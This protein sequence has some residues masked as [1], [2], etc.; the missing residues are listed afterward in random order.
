MPTYRGRTRADPLCEPPQ[1]ILTSLIIDAKQSEYYSDYA[2]WGVERATK[3]DA[4]I[5][6]QPGAQDPTAQGERWNYKPDHAGG[7][8]RVRLRMTE[9]QR[10][11]CTGELLHNR[12]IADDC[13]TSASALMGVLKTT[14]VLRAYLDKAG[15]TSGIQR[16]KSR[17][18]PN[19]AWPSE[20]CCLPEVSEAVRRLFSPRLFPDGDK[21]HGLG[22][23]LVCLSEALSTM[24]YEMDLAIGSANAAAVGAAPQLCGHCYCLL[25]A[26]DLSD[27]LQ[28]ETVHV[29]EG[30]NW[31]R[32]HRPGDHGPGEEEQFNRMSI[33]ASALMELTKSPDR[34]AQEDIGKGGVDMALGSFYKNIFVY[35]DSI[36][37]R[38]AESENERQHCGTFVFGIPTHTLTRG[39]SYNRAIPVGYHLVC[40]HL[41]EMGEHIEPQDVCDMV[42]RLGREEAVPPWGESMW[43][44]VLD[45]MYPCSRT[46]Y[47]GREGVE[48]FDAQRHVRIC[49][50]HEFQGKDPEAAALRSFRESI[51]GILLHGN[52][53]GITQR[54]ADRLSEPFKEI[55]EGFPQPPLLKLDVQQA[56][57]CVE[58][59]QRFVHLERAFTCMQA[60][61]TVCYIRK[62]QLQTTLSMLTSWIHAIQSAQE[63]RLNALS[64]ESMHHP[65]GLRP[66]YAPYPSVPG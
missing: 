6:K 40:R 50:T 5:N 24:S 52:P 28:T 14:M 22:L 31:T 11:V 12:I 64:H 56:N 32:Q 3:E 63:A 51:E 39:V 43:N 7:Y 44:T 1:A 15:V 62:D 27:G 47:D 9:D 37:M 42:R 21:D 55:K 60:L 25:K 17:P 65:E 20:A 4:A 49:M 54:H 18:E 41:Q 10:Q 33:V 66:E 23:L 38:Y 29:V 61:V 57:K 35:G 58:G 16:L 19:Q 2:I 8:V 59:I 26:T 45:S 48:A 36:Q 46:L 30:T 34:A 53:P 13:E